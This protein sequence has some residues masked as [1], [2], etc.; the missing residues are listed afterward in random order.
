MPKEGWADKTPH[1]TEAAGTLGAAWGSHKLP[2]R[3]IGPFLWGKLA[4]NWPL[5]WL[6]GPL[7]V[8]TTPLVSM[9]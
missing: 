4:P 9:P 7:D 5:L 2:V 6:Q 3:P 8:I 1:T